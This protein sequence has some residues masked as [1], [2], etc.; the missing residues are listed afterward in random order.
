VAG[1]GKATGYP[2]SMTVTAGAL[3]YNAGIVFLDLVGDLR[4]DAGSCGAVSQSH[5]VFWLAC[6]NPRSSASR[7]ADVQ[8][9]PVA[10]LP[11]G[12]YSCRT[13][14]EALAHI[15]GRYEYTG[16]GA[17]GSLMLT[18]DASK[19]TAQYSGDGSLAGTLRFTATTSTTASAG[20]GQTL[21]APCMNAAAM[22]QSSRTP[23]LV[24]IAAASLSIL[25]ST[26][27]LSFAGT[28]ADNSSCPGAKVAGSLICT[29]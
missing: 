21:M 18:D 5:A 12:H 29:K 20:P 22:R 11:A 25:D 10:Q 28:T 2:A 27:F 13:Q 7:S 17:T 6:E 1:P 3:T 16:G 26:L 4:S 23:E 15:N 24:P 19:V 8:P 14:I 9:V